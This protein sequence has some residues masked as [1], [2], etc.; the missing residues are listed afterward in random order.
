L[1]HLKFDSI[2]DIPD[3]RLD[4]GFFYIQQN[5]IYRIESNKLNLDKLIK[6]GKLPEGT[7]IVCQDE[8]MKD[9][10]GEKNKGWHQYISAN[11]NKREYSSYNNKVETGFYEAFVWYVTIRKC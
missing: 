1:Y 3:N 2:D 9:A 11:G 7:S 10:L 4:L 5:K 8:A 6:T